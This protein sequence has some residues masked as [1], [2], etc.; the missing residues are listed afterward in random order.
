[1]TEG[2]PTEGISIYQADMY[3]TQ[4]VSAAG[5]ILSLT[6]AYLSTKESCERRFL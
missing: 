2:P 6:E 4:K 3:A 1:M 5:V